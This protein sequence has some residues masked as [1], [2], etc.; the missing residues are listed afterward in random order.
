MIHFK[1][2]FILH[3]DIILTDTISIYLP[4]LASIVIF[5]FVIDNNY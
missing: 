2:T 4:E 5:K 1:S 3:I